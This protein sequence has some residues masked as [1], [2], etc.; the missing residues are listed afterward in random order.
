[1]SNNKEFYYKKFLKMIYDLIFEI[2]N[3][4]TENIQD[5][6]D[7][8]V[9]KFINNYITESNFNLYDL[10]LEQINLPNKLSL[11]DNNRLLMIFVYQEE[12]L[13]KFDEFKS[14][15]EK[16]IIEIKEKLK[17]KSF[18]DKEWKELGAKLKDYESIKKDYESRFIESEDIKKL[19]LDYLINQFSEHYLDN[20]NQFD[21]F[22]KKNETNLKKIR[23]I[24]KYERFSIFSSN[25]FKLRYDEDHAIY[26]EFNALKNKLAEYENIA[27]DYYGNFI[28]MKNHL[29]EKNIKTFY[30]LKKIIT[31]TS[32]I[33]LSNKAIFDIINLGD[34]NMEWFLLILRRLYGKKVNEEDLMKEFFD[35]FKFK[36]EEFLEEISKPYKYGFLNLSLIINT[37]LYY[38]ITLDLDLSKE[39]TINIENIYAHKKMEILLLFFKKLYKEDLILKFFESFELGNKKNLNPNEIIKFFNNNSSLNLTIEKLKIDELQKEDEL[40]EDELEEDE[41]EEDELEEDKLEKNE[42]QIKKENYKIKK[43][44]YKEKLNIDIDNLINKFISLNSQLTSNEQFE[45]FKEKNEKNI[46]ILQEILDD[47]RFYIF[48]NNNQEEEKIEQFESRNGISHPVFYEGSQLGYK[49]EIYEK[50]AKDYKENFIEMKKKL[51]EKKIRILYEYLENNQSIMIFFNSFPQDSLFNIINLEKKGMDC[52]LILLNELDGKKLT[53]KFLEILKS[54]NQ[55]FLEEILEPYQSGFLESDKIADFVKYYDNLNLKLKLD[56]TNLIENSKKIKNI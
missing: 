13:K 9:K 48:G 3:Q 30:F 46:D 27:K 40:E 34:E 39:K 8:L 43:K 53:E 24:L 47:Q 7:H 1:M 54:K 22:K 55:K 32:F 50:I 25:S 38:N 4:S 52:F 2:K 36:G 29:F 56:D 21:K 41:L 45:K 51:F 14:E 31:T 42:L 12:I 28:K 15:N 11:L 37:I 33:E 6:I 26:N 5:L 16:N 17:N 44:N 20:N 49:I 18:K 23:E 19:E 35:E 10:K